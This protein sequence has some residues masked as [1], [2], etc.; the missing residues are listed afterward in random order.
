MKFFAAFALIATSSAVTIE[1]QQTAISEIATGMEV[2]EF[3]QTLNKIDNRIKE[4]EQEKAST[5][6]TVHSM[7]SIN[8]KIKQLEQ[9]QFDLN[10]AI[11]LGQG[12]M[13][14]YMRWATHTIIV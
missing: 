14:K 3:V 13:N 6:E 8:Q 9:N 7:E 5:K 10:G 12:L 2:V 11:R 4:R 1:Q